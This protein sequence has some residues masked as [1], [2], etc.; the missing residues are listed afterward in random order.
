MNNSKKYKHPRPICRR[1]RVQHASVVSTERKNNYRKLIIGWKCF[2]EKIVWI[3]LCQSCRKMSFRIYGA[4]WF[5]SQTRRKVWHTMN[6]IKMDILTRYTKM[7][8]IRVWSAW[9]GPSSCPEASSPKAV[10]RPCM[11]LLESGWRCRGLILRGAIL[12]GFAP[13]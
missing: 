4:E 13:K 8:I 1:C 10:K 5:H 11:H 9:T 2:Y 6:L 3:K 12:E 7:T